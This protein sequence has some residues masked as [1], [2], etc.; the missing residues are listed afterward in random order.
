GQ[1]VKS[2]LDELTKISN[3]SSNIGILDEKELVYIYRSQSPNPIRI[4][5]HI[6]KRFPAYCTASGQLLLAHSS[7]DIEEL[8]LIPYT[9]KTITSHSELI[10]KLEQIKKL[11]YAITINELHAGVTAV[12]AP[13]T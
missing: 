2:I 13:I 1:E 6:G 10:N 3:E 12:A 8:D 7:V 4:K 9:N 5:S 11:G